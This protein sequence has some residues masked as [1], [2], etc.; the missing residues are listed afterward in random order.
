[1]SQPDQV[2]PS[3]QAPEP[4]DARPVA[5]ER[6]CLMVARVRDGDAATFEAIFRAHWEP[7][8]RF[9]LRYL[10]SAD[11]AEDAVQTVF[12]RIWRGRAVWRV[13]GG[14]VD[15]LYLAV[16]NAS[17]DRLEHRAVVRRWR[18]RRVEEIRR[19]AIDDPGHA[20]EAD[21][22]LSRAELDA[23]VE[24]GLAELPPK[25]REICLLRLFHD[26]SYAQIAARLN[27]SL[28]TVETQLARGLRELR[29]RVQARRS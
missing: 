5:S 27:I 6:E 8:V 22:L 7:L 17:L 26:L 16:R 24:R 25:R 21:A 13:P 4:E 23:A 12:A 19:A 10:R 14:L 9:A 18:E 11:D 3:L 2:G 1:M 15:Y 29:G 28:K 20:P